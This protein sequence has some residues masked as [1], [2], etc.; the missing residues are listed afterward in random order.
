MQKVQEKKREL[1]IE[2]AT[3]LKNLQ[4]IVGGADCCLACGLNGA[5]LTISRS[6][7]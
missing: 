3:K 4:K 2:G 5:V 6:T 7:N 1:N